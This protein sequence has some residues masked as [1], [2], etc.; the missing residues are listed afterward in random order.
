MVSGPDVGSS[1]GLGSLGT[2]AALRFRDAWLPALRA[3]GTYRAFA[4]GTMAGMVGG[5]WR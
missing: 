1:G 2:L 3:P 5:W 4:G